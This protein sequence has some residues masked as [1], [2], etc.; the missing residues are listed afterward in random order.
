MRNPKMHQEHKQGLDK[1][2]FSLSRSCLLLSNIQP[3]KLTKTDFLIFSD[4]AHN[5]WFKVN[6]PEVYNAKPPSAFDLGLTETGNDVDALARG[7]FPGGVELGRGQ[8]ERTRQLVESRSPIL[9][10]PTFET[11]RFSTACDILVLT[12]RP[13]ST[14]SMR[15]RHQ[16]TATTRRQRTS[17]IRTTSPSRL[18]C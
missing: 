8:I 4:C 12:R 16:P 5:A 1:T 6:Q 17:S 3:L 2:K 15:L 9:Y 13:A 10:Q 18:T 11:G 14:T 7:L